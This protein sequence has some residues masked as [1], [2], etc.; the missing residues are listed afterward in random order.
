[1]RIA[2]MSRWNATCGVSLHAELIGRAFN[3]MGHDIIVF[4]PTIES[5]NNDWHHRHLDVP[6]EPWVYRVYGETSSYEY[7]DGGWLDETVFT[8]M[9]YDILVVEGYHRLPVKKLYRVVKKIHGRTCLVLV[10]H[11]LF[12]RDLEPLMKIN[13][14]TIIVF[15]KRYI[16]EMIKY[17]GKEAL[18]KTVII[19]YPYA[20]PRFIKPYRPSFA[21]DK[22]LFITYGRQPV[23]EY[24]DYIYVLDK[25]SRKYDLVYWVIRSDS[26]LPF[27]Y[28]W[29]IQ[30]VKRPSIETI[31]SYVMGSDL[32]LLPKSETRGVVV[33][34]T[35]AQILYSGTPIIV[36]DTRYFETIPVDHNGYGPV[37]KYKLGNTIDLYLKIKELIEDDELWRRVSREARRYA[38]KYSSDKIAKVFIDVFEKLYSGEAIALYKA[39]N[40]LVRGLN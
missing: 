13:W 34:S 21:E 22:K 20:T 12:L 15:D 35:I 14:D 38:L 33:S 2:I 16:D 23:Y 37:V 17:F 19:P 24:M 8:T 11:T 27:K 18:D 31:Y 10:V 5:A 32:H 25:L 7:P 30:E 1:M 36:P 6:D 28:E 39:G 26:K 3:R 9:D 29:L 4:A 40:S